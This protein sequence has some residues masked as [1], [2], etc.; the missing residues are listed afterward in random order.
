MS[1]QEFLPVLLSVFLL[2]T[3]ST[4]GGYHN[5]SDIH[6]SSSKK[7]QNIKNVKHGLSKTFFRLKKDGL[8]SEIESNEDQKANVK[9][10]AGQLPLKKTL[11]YINDMAYAV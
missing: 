1:N 11:L 3:I 5:S 7:D 4:G 10:S 9:K 2:S 8:S 6:Y